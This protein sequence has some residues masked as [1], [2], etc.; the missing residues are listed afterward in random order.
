MHARIRNRVGEAVQGAFLMYVSEGIQTSDGVLI[1]LPPGNRLV[2]IPVTSVSIIPAARD[3]RHKDEGG[4]EPCGVSKCGM[5]DCKNESECLDKKV[6][7]YEE[8]R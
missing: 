4:A 1:D 3:G 8:R 7:R 5:H 6:L 2:F